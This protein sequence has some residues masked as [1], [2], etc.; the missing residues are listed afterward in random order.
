[1]LIGFLHTA[2]ADRELYLHLHL[3]GEAL[4]YFD[5]TQAAIRQDYDLAITALRQRY[6]NPQ[7]QEL[8]QIIFFSITQIQ[9]R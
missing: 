3:K 7:R 8:K 5:Q 9:N 1:M 2:D 4:A 6:V